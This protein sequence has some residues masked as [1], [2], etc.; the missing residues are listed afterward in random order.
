VQRLLGLSETVVVGCGTQAEAQ[1]LGI[2][3]GEP[4]GDILEDDK[5]LSTLEHG[6][7]LLRQ[8]SRI[9]RHEPG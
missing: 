9:A 6:R 8:L 3:L 4:L 5:S 2:E 1:E 7:R